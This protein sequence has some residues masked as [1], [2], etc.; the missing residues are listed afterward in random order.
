MAWS[1]VEYIGPIGI[2]LE[3]TSVDSVMRSMDNSNTV[4]TTVRING[5]LV[6]ETELR[7]TVLQKFTTASVACHD[8]V[9]QQTAKIVF[10]VL[11]MYFWNRLHLYHGCKYRPIR[12]DQSTNQKCKGTCRTERETSLTNLPWLLSQ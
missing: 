11:G 12:S 1:S 10:Q 2:Q 7:I 9:G 8:V 3:L 5:T 4:A 6:I